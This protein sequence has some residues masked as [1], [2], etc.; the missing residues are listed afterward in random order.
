[1]KLSLLLKL[2]L[3]CGSSYSRETGLDQS[4]LGCNASLSIVKS[5]REHL[6]FSTQHNDITKQFC[7]HIAAIYAQIF[8]A[9]SMYTKLFIEVF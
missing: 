1:M 6:T 7:V 4:L 5:A 9:A 2:I 8:M 3:T